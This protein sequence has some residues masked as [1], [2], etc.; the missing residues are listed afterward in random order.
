[1]AQVRRRQQA[2][3]QRRDAAICARGQVAVAQHR[4][5]TPSPPPEGA[6]TRQPTNTALY[7]PNAEAALGELDVIR[8]N[9]ARRQ[10]RRPRERTLRK[11][12][13]GLESR[14]PA[15]DPGS[16]RLKATPSETRIASLQGPHRMRDSRAAA[17]KYR[18]REDRIVRRSTGDRRFDLAALRPRNNG[19]SLSITAAQLREDDE[20]ELQRMAGTTEGVASTPRCA[21]R[22]GRRGGDDLNT[23]RGRAADGGPYRVR[24]HR[25]P[26]RWRRRAASRWPSRT[27]VANGSAFRRRARLR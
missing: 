7:P 15:R 13:G 11:K 17:H 8:K 23:N 12:L 27:P 21:K 2:G 1:M 19:R 5:V 25:Q 24:V 6:A 4:D 14:L 26:A 18:N 9:R 10:Y 3:R 22:R 16:E 20:Q